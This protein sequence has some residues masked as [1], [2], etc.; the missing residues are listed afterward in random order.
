[1]STTPI[2]VEIDGSNSNTIN[3]SLAGSNGGTIN[4]TLNGYSFYEGG[5]SIVSGNTIKEVPTLS[6][7]TLYTT[8]YAYATSKLSVFLNGLREKDVTEV[9]GT[10][11]SV[12]F[13]LGTNDTIVAEYIKS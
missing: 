8:T 7:G 5:A 4:V 11:F 10:S 3:V 6:S 9:D 13:A 1:M 2:N 12:P